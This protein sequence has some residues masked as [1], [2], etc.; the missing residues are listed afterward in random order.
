M[1]LDITGD[2]Y[3]RR[4]SQDSQ[5][6]SDGLHNIYRSARWALHQTDASIHGQI[7]FF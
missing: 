6:A 3:G 5:E 4:V 2:V 7:M 1:K